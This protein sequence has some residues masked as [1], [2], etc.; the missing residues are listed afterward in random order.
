MVGQWQGMKPIRVKLSG[1]LDKMNN[2]CSFVPSLQHNGYKILKMR[3]ATVPRWRGQG[4]GKAYVKICAGLLTESLNLFGQ[5]CYIQLT[6][7]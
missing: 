7:N 1:F 3:L 5:L 2:P 6:A 4:G